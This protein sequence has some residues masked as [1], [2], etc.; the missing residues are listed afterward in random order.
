MEQ[1][2]L[3]HEST[4][5]GAVDSF[6]KELAHVRP[7]LLQ[8]YTPILEGMAERW[9]TEGGANRISALNSQ[10]LASYLV[11]IADAESARQVLQEFYRWAT[12][13]SL[14]TDNPLDQFAQ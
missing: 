1:I 14:V 12:Q 8:R 7:Y 2:E 4:L 6:L 13:Q 9:L 10:W 3:V 11:E 5:V